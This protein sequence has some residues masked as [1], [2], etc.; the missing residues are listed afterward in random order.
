MSFLGPESRGVPVSGGLA[1]KFLAGV[2]GLIGGQSWE[3]VWLV[4]V[5]S[6]VSLG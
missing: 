3:L 4:S 6:G 2:S 5:F 1:E